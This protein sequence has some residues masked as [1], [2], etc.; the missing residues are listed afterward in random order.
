MPD[1]TPTTS[2]DNADATDVSEESSVPTEAETGRP[3]FEHYFQALGE[4]NR[5]TGAPRFHMPDSP[6]SLP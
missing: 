2:A 1:E 5:K 6:R 3:S 4:E